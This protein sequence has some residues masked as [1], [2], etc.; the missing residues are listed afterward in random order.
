MSTYGFKAGLLTE[1]LRGRKGRNPRSTA[2]CGD[3]HKLAGPFDPDL[4]P[5]RSA[6]ARI[7]PARGLAVDAPGVRFTAFGAGWPPSTA[8]QSKRISE[9]AELLK[10]CWIDKPQ[11]PHSG[12]WGLRPRFPLQTTANKGIAPSG[13]CP[14]NPPPPWGKHFSRC[15]QPAS[16]ARMPLASSSY[17]SCSRNTARPRFLQNSCPHAAP[18][19]AEHEWTVSKPAEL[20]APADCEQRAA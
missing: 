19:S 16:I 10:R 13:H 18:Q 20:M 1:P 9:A 6:Q 7:P 17:R 2:L 15:W 5:G 11:P 3:D 8:P 12:D 14:Q 4:V